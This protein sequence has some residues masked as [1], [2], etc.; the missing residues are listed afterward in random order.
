[1]PQMPQSTWP[2]LPDEPVPERPPDVAIPSFVNSQK[3]L[4]SFDDDGQTDSERENSSQSI[5]AKLKNDPEF[6]KLSK[7]ERVEYYT[8]LLVEKD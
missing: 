2:P 5:V 6:L 4:N 7:R 8:N 1:M 3:P